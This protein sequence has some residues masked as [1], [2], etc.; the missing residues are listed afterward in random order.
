MA[1]SRVHFDRD[2]R[3]RCGTP[4]QVTLTADGGQVTCGAC[5]S[6]LAGTHGAG[7][8]W[9]DVRPCP[10]PAA[11][12]R[13]LRAGG[14]VHGECRRAANRDAADRK[15]RRRREGKALAA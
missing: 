3:P 8:R 2:G 14:P 5:L 1:K 15:A 7:I 13:E 10:S 9:S 6:L 4:W 12:R 11:Y